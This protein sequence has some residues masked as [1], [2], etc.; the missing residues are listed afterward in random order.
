MR[1]KGPGGA[2]SMACSFCAPTTYVASPKTPLKVARICALPGDSAV[3]SPR[4]PPAAD[5]A[6]TPPSLLVQVA[7]DVRSTAA[8]LDSTAMALNW[9]RRPTG[10][11]EAGGV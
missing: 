3:A 4:V 11:A 1:V 5:T 7:C 10:V 8:R 9:V 6:A 2:T